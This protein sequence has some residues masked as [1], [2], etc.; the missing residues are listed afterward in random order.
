MF[1]S[2]ST[3]GEKHAALQSAAEE[4][5]AYFQR[6]LSTEVGDML[7]VTPIERWHPSG[8]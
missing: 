8:D 2:P 7:Q 6:D 1:S 5:T 4:L 3:E